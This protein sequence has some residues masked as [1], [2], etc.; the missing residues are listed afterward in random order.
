[1]CLREVRR[2]ASQPL[3]FL[4]EAPV[5][6]PKLTQLGRLIG[7]D[8]GL[9]AVLD[10]GLAQPLRQR[11][12][13]NPE[14]G[15]DLLES[16]TGSTI[17]GDPDHVFLEL[18]GISASHV[19]ILPARTLVLAD[20]EVPYRCSRPDIDWFMLLVNGYTPQ[21]QKAAGA[22]AVAPERVDE[23]QLVAAAGV[24]DEDK[25]RIAADLWSVFGS[26]TPRWW[27]DTRQRDYA[28]VEATA[29]SARHG[30]WEEC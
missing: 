3:D 7:R 22:D 9:D 16:L 6:S 12:R 29:K 15:R 11:N 18:L 30:L 28:E 8:T 23:H 2:R 17:P 20:L 10:V 21:A 25:R 24:T 26:S 14:V 13:V 1:M 5:A 19:N 27:H 4:L